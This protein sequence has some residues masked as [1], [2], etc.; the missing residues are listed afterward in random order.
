MYVSAI[1]EDVPASW[2]LR[3]YPPL[4]RL[5]QHFKNYKLP[6]SV[7]DFEKEVSKFFNEISGEPLTKDCQVYV[8]RYAH[9][10]MSSGMICGSFWIGHGIPLL[11]ER[12]KKI[13]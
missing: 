10:G 1:F 3:G 4:G 12:L 13:S 11:V 8:A 7:R 5:K 9:G 2:G 6:F